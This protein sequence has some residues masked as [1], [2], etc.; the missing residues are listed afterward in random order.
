MRTGALGAEKW[1]TLR[2]PIAFFCRGPRSGEAPETLRRQHDVAV[3][4]RVAR[5]EVPAVKTREHT[6]RSSYST[7]DT[8]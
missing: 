2:R 7:I 8:P 4:L 1:L 6:A 3:P 5:H